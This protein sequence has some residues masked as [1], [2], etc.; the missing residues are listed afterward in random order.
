MFKKFDVID[1]G[2]L[3]IKKEQVYKTIAS[4]NKT[5]VTDYEHMQLHILKT[6]NTIIK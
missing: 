1:E 2:M 5:R 6:K 3:S 4:R